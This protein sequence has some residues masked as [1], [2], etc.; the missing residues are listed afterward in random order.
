MRTWANL[1][2]KTDVAGILE[3]TLEEEKAADEKLTGIAES[4]VNAAAANEGGE[5]EDHE[6]TTKRGSRRAATA[7]GR[8]IAADRKRR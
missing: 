7:R 8:H 3:E 4:F 1:L 6:E 2:G 5:D